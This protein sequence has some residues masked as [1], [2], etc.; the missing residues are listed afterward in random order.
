MHSFSASGSVVALL[1]GLKVDLRSVTTVQCDGLLVASV[2]DWNLLSDQLV[3]SED[4]YVEVVDISTLIGL[5][6]EL[7]IFVVAVSTVNI[8][9]QA[10]T[11]NHLLHLN[12]FC[13]V[14]YWA[15]AV[16]DT[17]FKSILDIAVRLI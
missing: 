3:I 9:E 4:L 14:F 5:L 8:N 2:S 10:V 7:E 13:Q 17:L 6:V 11:F 16:A 15:W 1:D 12:V